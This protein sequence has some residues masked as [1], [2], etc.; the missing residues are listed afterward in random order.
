MSK[1]HTFIGTFI[2]VLK[3][4]KDGSFRTQNDRRK[5]LILI[6]K[7]LWSLGYKLD[8][9]QFIRS[10]HIYKLVGHWKANGDSVGTLRNKTAT[11]RWLMEKFNKA[12]VVP[13]NE[14]LNIPKRH[15]ATHVDKSRQLTS[16]DLEEINNPY[17]KLSLK[18]Q[19][20]FGLRLEESLKIQ[21]F[22][23]D[24]GDRLF[25]KA[26]WTKGG[27][28]R[29]VPIV[30]AEQ[31]DWLERAKALVTCKNRSL[32]PA[33]KSYKTHRDAVLK[34]YQRHNISKTHGLRHHYAQ[35]RYQVLTGW[36]CPAKGGLATQQLTT[37]QQEIDKAARLKITEE[38]G[39]SRREIVKIYVN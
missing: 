9:A 11:L 16:A 26:S 6:A 13:S 3:H 20:L 23:A 17:Y 2:N 7:T 38:L 29:Y 5:L 14:A 21:P 4:N 36:L 1:K 34:Y 18:A 25:L 37:E 15:Y 35:Q 8:S 31:R 10:R 30:T 39:H 24:K 22:I 12:N 19:Q 33:D 27:R 32:I 28:R